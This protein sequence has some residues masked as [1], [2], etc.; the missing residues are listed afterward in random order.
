MTPLA[1]VSGLMLGIGVW[2]IASGLLPARPQ[3]LSHRIAPYLIDVS[4]A[5][6]RMVENTT[7][8]PV[9]VFGYLLSPA[10]KR[11]VSRVDSIFGGGT[12]RADRLARSGTPESPADFAARRVAS[13]VIGLS[14]GVLVGALGALWSSERG[15][16]G[17][18]AGALVGFVSGVWWVDYRLSKVI[19]ERD[20]RVQEEFPTII[21]LLG[22]AL[23]A[24][25]SLPRAL[26]RV[27]RRSQGELGREWARVM[28]L[29]DLGA[30]LAVSLRDSAARIGGGQVSAFVE[31]LAQALDQGAPLGEVVSAHARDAKEVYTRGLVDR[32]G[33]AEVQMLVPMV[34]LILPIT[35]IFAVYPGL[36][37]LQFGF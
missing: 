9:M 3:D 27:A 35:V 34:L 28:N 11:V 8:D 7:D 21:E 20:Q 10:L 17:A 12:S 15:M 26:A 18:L 29:V 22:L 1:V 30:P 4:P 31:H 2:S 5:A 32:A 23:A 37:A 25:D 24:G 13:G 14:A 19:V 6:R 16:V 36:Q 33:K